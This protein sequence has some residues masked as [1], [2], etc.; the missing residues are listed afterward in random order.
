MGRGPASL[1]MRISAA[2]RRAVD[3]MALS[4]K[5]RVA[6]LLCAIAMLTASAQFLTLLGG[7]I[8]ASETMRNTA[9]RIDQGEFP[10][11]IHPAGNA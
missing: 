2:L 1:D 5:H 3:P 11:P 10:E 9:S 8:A 4:Q 6:P 7:R